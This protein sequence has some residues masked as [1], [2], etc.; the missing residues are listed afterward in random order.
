[1]NL[2]SEAIE[3]AFKELQKRSQNV[4]Y[5]T[6][7]V[8]WARDVLKVEL[9]S[10]Q[11]EILESLVHNKKTAVKSSHAIGKLQT[12]S[13]RV[14]TPEGMR[15]FGDLRVGDYVL[16]VHGN[17][18]Q[19]TYV[20]EDQFHD[21]YDVVFDDGSRVEVGLDHLW[22]VQD[23]SKRPKGVSDWR[24]HWDNTTTVDTRTIMNNLRTDSGQYRW[25]V[26]IAGALQRPHNDSLPLDPYNLGLR[27][28]DGFSGQKYIPH[29]YLWNTS[30]EQRRAL[31]A[32]LMDS[33]GFVDTSNGID[34]ADKR[35][36]DGVLQLLHTLG[37]KASR[38]EGV[39]GT[40][41]RISFT[42]SWNPFRNRGEN[43]EPPKTG[44][45][46]LRTIVGVERSKNQMASRCITVDNE[47]EC[48]LTGQEFI[49][50]HNT[51]LSAV[52]V[53]WWVS[54]RPDGVV[55]TTAPTSYQVG[56][57]LWKEIRTMHAANGLVGD[58]NQNNE[59]KTNVNGAIN[60]VASGQ[61]PSDTSIHSFHGVHAT[62]GVLTILDEGCFSKDTEVL[63]ESGWKLWPEV[64]ISDR[65]LTMNPETR[66]TE[67]L[68]PSKMIA[69]KYTGKMHLYEAKG[70]NFMVTPNHEML[71]KTRANPNLRKAEMQ[72]F[73][74]LENKYFEK[75]IPWEGYAPETFTLPPVPERRG[76]GV[77]KTINIRDWATFL[78][79]FASE[80][81]IN[82]ELYT[83][84]I[85]QKKQEYRD[86][87]RELLERL[88]FNFFENENG[89][90]I[91][92]A[93]LAEHLAQ[94][95]RTCDVKRVPD[96]VREWTP[97]L[98]GLFIEAFRKGDGYIHR[99]QGILYTSCKD[100]ADDLQE[101]VLKMGLPSVVKERELGSSYY[102]K[103]D[104]WITS[105]RNGWYVTVP[106]K[107]TDIRLRNE[108]MSLVDY[109]DMVYCA[110]MPRNNTLFTRRKGYP[111]WS[112]NCGIVEALFTAAD[113]I[114]TGKRDRVLTVGNPDDPN[115]SFG[116]IFL[117]I[118]EENK[119]IWNRITVSAF[120]T[121]NFTGE[122]VPDVVRESL[123]QPDWVEARRIEWGED[124]G[125]Y[126]SKILGEFPAESD[127]SFFTQK[128]IDIA[129]DTEIDE[130]V[131]APLIF[132]VDIAGG[133]DDDT[134]IYSNKGGRIRRV[135]SWSQGNA[136]FLAKRILDTAIEHGADE[137]RIDNG[138]F[139]KG[140]ID[141]M[142]EDPRVSPFRIIRMMGG[143]QASDPSAHRNKR[144]ENYDY[145]RMRMDLGYVD[146]DRE[147]SKVRDQMLA[148][149]YEYT[150][151]GSIKMES[152]ADL[153]K[154]SGKSP[155]DL[156]AIVYAYADLSFLDEDTSDSTNHLDPR[157][158]F[159]DTPMWAQIPW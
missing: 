52:A 71:F 100:M 105:S 152:K 59:W 73:K 13:S 117:D 134:V 22:Q 111:F 144:A 68:N 39:D 158:Y 150:E 24:D 45:H 38:R 121:P 43:W 102:A 48:Y 109:D 50:T 129:Y 101:L 87:I 147:D 36:S 49:P 126:R 80:G 35:L 107:K 123:I 32:G 25:R 58:V 67:Y 40:R 119:D 60:T 6:D 131:D 20:T 65:L 120:D 47:L 88:P 127:N 90:G 93:Q 145:L 33:V 31:L 54:T 75:V 64:T 149:R 76:Q 42:T 108:S 92:S 55:R 23:H 37:I 11:R 3:S 118:T 130:D 16:D 5:L 136:L 132:G 98:I 103:E 81:S 78:G 99:S 151:R 9:W 17:P 116:K 69:Y 89:F 141:V 79:W 156:D 4:S 139:G 114:S 86:E 124:S 135:A 18:T 77:P 153:R 125:R 96:Y 12:L 122:P 82:K 97:E 30:E 44:K 84:S 74:T 142:L 62:G 29:D 53:C 27:L 94:Y 56:Q 61:K 10:K 115:T 140:V 83:V 104:R 148:V 138:G 57:L 2:N 106:P 14:P 19:V 143:D 51:F 28:R 95:G 66:E 21:I 70:A 157:D 1:M 15:L 155:D 133:G 146:L 112:G 41:Y 72:D 91:S 85:A 7:P 159:Q 110:T 26:P 46:T 34:L 154:R 137:I 63:T 128:G 113:A 8:G